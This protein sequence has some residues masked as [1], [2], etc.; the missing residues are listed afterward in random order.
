MNHANRTLTA[1]RRLGIVALLG[2]ATGVPQPAAAAEVVEL[3]SGQK[4]TTPL[5][6]GG[7]NYSLLGV[8][9]RSRQTGK[10]PKVL[11]YA[12]ALYVDHAAAKMPFPALYGKAPTRAMM[13]A[14][15]R[16][17]NF[18]LWGRFG[19][20]A[21]LRFIRP[22][23]KAEVVAELRGGLAEILT[24]KTADELR[25]DAEKFLLL[26][27]KDFKEGDELRIHTDETGRIEV[28]IDGVKKPGPHNP[29]LARHIWDIWLGSRAIAKDMRQSLVDKLDILKK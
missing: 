20:L 28:Q 29:K 6:L 16:A 7:A 3:A 9:L 27:D 1:A 2:L 22:Q 19:K 13:M 26:F 5:L 25:R 12:M 4:F 15:S 17:Q 14:E 11:L 21:V 18:V 24:D 8:G 23:T 10:E